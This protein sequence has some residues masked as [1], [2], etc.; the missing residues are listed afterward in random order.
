MPKRHVYYYSD[1]IIQ[2][3]NVR[4]RDYSESNNDYDAEYFQQGQPLV[5]GAF[6]MKMTS[7]IT[8]II[9]ICRQF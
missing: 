7:E 4:Q 8:T 3:A 1:P 9:K 6:P 5:A 2:P